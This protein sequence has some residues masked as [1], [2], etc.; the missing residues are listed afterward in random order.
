METARKNLL[1]SQQDRLPMPSDDLFTL[2]KSLTPAEKRY[3]KLIA[4]THASGE[5]T[6]YLLLFEAMDK[7]TEYDEE[8]IKK[9]YRKEKFVAQLTFTRNAL[10]NKILDALCAY[11]GGSKD[12]TIVFEF[13]QALNHLLALYRKGIYGQMEKDLKRLLKMAAD[14]E[15]PIYT[16]ELL[17]WQRRLLL[18][19]TD[20]NITE[21]LDALIEE[22]QRAQ[23]LLQNEAQFKH[24]HD[25]LLVSLKVRIRAKDAEALQKMEELIQIPLLQEEN[26]ALTRQAKLFYNEIWG[27]YHWRMGNFASMYAHHKRIIE[28][29]ETNDLFRNE[30]RHEYRKALCNFLNSCH[31]FQKFEDYPP[32]LVK[33]RALAANDVPTEVKIFHISFYHELLYY[34]NTFSIAKGVAE[35]PERLPQLEA[36]K[37][38]IHS[39]RLLTIYYNI[40]LV[41]FF[42]HRFGDALTWINE[43]LS[44][45]KAD[46]RREVYHTAHILQLAIHY[47]L[48]NIDLLENLH[49][50]VYRNLKN[51]DELQ[52]F[53]RL[54][55]SNFKKLA[56]VNEYDK[57]AMRSYFESFDKE[58]K[59]QLSEFPQQ[60]LLGWF[61]IQTW[62]SSKLNGM[63]MSEVLIQN[64]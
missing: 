18:E 45:P 41:Y 21:D 11:I 20:R 44:H 43:I 63:T 9:K 53:E 27:F 25:R 3:F 6:N 42:A 38:Q 8:A 39:S 17:Q 48:G 10:R 23:Q 26:N 28:I 15:M 56:T 60:H 13:R 7:Q 47:E 19:R 33:I 46:T 1:L 62:L 12:N 5:A 59:E 54:L 51:A 22:E 32:T 14:Y 24:L 52:L 58:L 4:Q 30:H 55:L 34:L 29:W 16:L 31:A 40:A 57:K 36:W 37:D 50:S 35:I 61:E 2:V 49:R 64:K